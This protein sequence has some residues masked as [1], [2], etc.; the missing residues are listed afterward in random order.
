MTKTISRLAVQFSENGVT[1]NE[2]NN[3]KSA[4]QYQ[5]MN[6]RDSLTIAGFN[7]LEDL[8]SFLEHNSDDFEL[9]KN[10]SAYT[11]YKAYFIQSGVE[12]N[13]YY[14]CRRSRLTYI[15]VRPIMRA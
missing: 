4:Y 2:T 8:L 11:T 3:S 13:Q 9:W 10:S 7:V 5:E 1:R 12:L 6:L 14:D 15:R